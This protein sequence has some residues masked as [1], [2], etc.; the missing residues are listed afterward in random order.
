MRAHPVIILYKNMIW[1]GFGIDGW[2]N[3]ATPEQ[4][5]TAQRELWK[6]LSQCPD[7]LPV[8]ASFNLSQIHEAINVVRT[9]KRPGKVLVVG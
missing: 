3:N 4:L 8:I 1:Q 9:A 5:A 7:L 2:L 6:M